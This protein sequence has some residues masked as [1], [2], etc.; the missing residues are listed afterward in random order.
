MLAK[1]TRQIRIGA[2]G[3]ELVKYHLLA[4]DWDV[5]N[6]N[7]IGNNRPN[8]DLLAVKGSRFVRL[9]VKTS[10]YKDAVQ[11]GWIEE[12][13][14]NINSK[15]G[16]P[17]DYFVM[18]GHAAPGDYSIHVIPAEVLA[19]WEKRNLAAHAKHGRIKNPG[20]VYFGAKNR[21]TK[22]DINQDGSEFEQYKNAWSS[23]E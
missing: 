18:V 3:E 9:Q 20:Y 2:I 21:K 10:K 16:D 22:F 6:L 12:G 14:S 11:L 23:L 13:K 15:I 19:K 1:N 8:A 5:I 4:R 7:S 17:A